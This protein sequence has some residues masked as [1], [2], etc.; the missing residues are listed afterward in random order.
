[1]TLFDAF[2][3]ITASTGAPKIILVEDLHW[4]DTG[5]EAFLE[6]LAKATLEHATLLLLN[7][8]PEYED[9]WLRGA[10]AQLIQLR[11]LG[12][13]EIAELLSE[14]LGVDPSALELHERIRSRAGG[15]PFFVEEVVRSLVETGTLLGTSGAYRLVEPLETLAIPATVHGILAARID[16]LDE[17]QKEVLQAAAVI[18]KE[19]SERLLTATT[20]LAPDEL[21]SVLGALETSEFI[22]LE[23]LYPRKEYAFKHPLTLDVVYGSQLT[24]R[25]ARI[26]AAVARAIEAEGCG[27][28]RLQECAPLLAHHFELAGDAENAAGWHLQ[29]GQR[30]MVAEPRESLRHYRKALKLL[31]SVPDSPENIALSVTARAA[32][33]STSFLVPVSQE[34]IE[35]VFAEGKALAKQ[36]QDRRALAVL[37][38]ASGAAQ[39]ASGDADRALEHAQRANEL[40]RETGDVEFEASLRTTL[41]FAYYAAGLLREGLEYAVELDARLGST[42]QGPLEPKDNFMSGGFRAMMSMHMGRLADAEQ[43]LTRALRLAAEVGKSFSWMHACLVDTAFY[44][45]RTEGALAH[46]RSAVESAERYGSPYFS[47]NAYR[48]LGLAHLLNGEWNE[49]IPALRQGLSIVR[50]TRS[51]LHLQAPILAQ[52][53][54]AH[55]GAGDEERALEYAEEAV[56]TARQ[57]RTRLWESK[58]LLA[59]ARVLRETRGV[60]AA[61]EIMGA[62]AELSDLIAETGAESLTPFVHLERGRLARLSGDRARAEGELLEA[63]RLFEQIGATGHAAA[64]AEIGETEGPAP[65]EAL[66]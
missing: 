39:S 14:L 19:F 3:G 31:E 63:R 9:A 12:D 1:Q 42:G 46:G 17:R 49:A 53:A 47:A 10:G 35:R 36:S 44:S 55:L 11:P 21:S 56:T 4:L 33:I 58:A 43:A 54:E 48:A 20:G 40:A 61:D 15:N 24:D 26:H 57:S 59:K 38:N 66:H 8:R 16:R 28:D 41:T 13:P 65:G 23:R 2:R 51:A 32:I 22:Y 5:S 29:A 52:L 50:D 25:R 34:E 18:G 6:Q 30:A 27:C 37:L 60:E 64:L 7:Y 62:L 45:G